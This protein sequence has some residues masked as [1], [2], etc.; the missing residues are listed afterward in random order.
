MKHPIQI[1]TGL[2]C[3][4]IVFAVVVRSG[5]GP[6]PAVVAGVATAALIPFLL[7]PGDLSAGR[8]MR[9]LS[10]RER[11]KVMRSVIRVEG[12]PDR[13]LAAAAVDY[14]EYLQRIGDWG[15][16]PGQL[17]FA[18]TGIVFW[19]V[20]AVAVIANRRYAG[21]VIPVLFIV[22]GAWNLWSRPRWSRRGAE[23]ER[24]NR[25]LLGPDQ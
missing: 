12:V 20:I 2:A 6:V 7:P 24:M 11:L 23:A 13:R 10:A 25:P 19:G 17:A 4:V 14:A 18:V 5:T 9:S 15:A 22:L 3:G 1:V 8:A 16:S 21:L